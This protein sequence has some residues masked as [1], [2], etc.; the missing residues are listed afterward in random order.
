[1][2]EG[3]RRSHDTLPY[4]VMYE[5]VPEGMHKGMHCPPE[6]LEGML[7]TYYKLRGWNPEGI[8]TPEKLQTLG[9]TS[10]TGNLP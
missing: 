1:M 3:V 6:E 7:D 2:R 4:R 8:P 10:L 9:L 5:P